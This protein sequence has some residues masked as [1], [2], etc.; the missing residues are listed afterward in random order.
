MGQDG[1]IRVSKM[2]PMES[3]K[4]GQITL[5]PLHV[6]FT[7]A[8]ATGGA[9]QTYYEWS[10]WHICA[11]FWRDQETPDLELFIQL[12]TLVQQKTTNPKICVHCTGGI[13]RTGVYVT[14]DIA[15]R[16]MSKSSDGS[17]SID[18]TLYFLP[19]N[20]H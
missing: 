5:T 4:E 1:V 15:A 7:L 8:G 10:C 6:S 2:G 20:F 16:E 9:A 18:G 11:F 13:G 14:V 3:V 17:V 19:C 12:W